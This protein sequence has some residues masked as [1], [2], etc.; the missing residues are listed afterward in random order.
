MSTR[1]ATTTADQRI[2]Y[3][4]GAGGQL[5]RP[6]WRIQIQQ[7]ELPARFRADEIYTDGDRRTELSRVTHAVLSRPGHLAIGIVEAHRAGVARQGA[8]RILR[9]EQRPLTVGPFTSIGSVERPLRD[10][11]MLLSGKLAMNESV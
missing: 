1:P 5:V 9:I 4:H 2:E 11:S 10:R 7:H 8:R 6:Q 3:G